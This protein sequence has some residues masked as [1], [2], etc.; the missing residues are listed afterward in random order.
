MNINEI[1]T[2]I[3]ATSLVS[4][5]RAFLGKNLKV[6]LIWVCWGFGV[7]FF[8]CMCVGAGVLLRIGVVLSK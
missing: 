5:P 3:G 1:H 7:V 4:K 6:K 2:Q 8:V